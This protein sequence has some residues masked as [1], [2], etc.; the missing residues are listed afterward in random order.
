LNGFSICLCIRFIRIHADILLLVFLYLI[1]LLTI[2]AIFIYL[3]CK[4]KCWTFSLFW[5]KSNLP[6]KLLCYFIWNY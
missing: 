1:I 5:L 6:S 2:L 3:K 4:L